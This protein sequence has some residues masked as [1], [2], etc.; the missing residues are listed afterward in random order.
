MQLK[1][2]ALHR[3]RLR[4]V[5]ALLLFVNSALPAGG[6][7]EENTGTVELTYTL[8]DR[9]SGDPIACEDAAVATIELLLYTTVGQDPQILS[10]PCNATA[11]APGKA[12]FTV[13]KGTY[14][15]M[16]IKMLRSDGGPSCRANRTQA[17]WTF[18]K[19]E[20]G[21]RV[22]AGGVAVLQEITAEFDPA[23]LPQCGNGQREACEECDDG[24]TESGDGCSAACLVES[25]GECGNGE[26]EPGE[27]CDDGNTESGDGCTA[28]CRLEQADLTVTWRPWDGSAEITCAD[29]PAETITVSVIPTGEATPVASQSDLTCTDLS[30]VFEDLAFGVYDIEILGRD[31][32]NTLSAFGETLQHTHTALEGSTATVDITPYAAP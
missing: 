28:D 26:V 20:A 32:E 12:A 21:A 13:R 5:T 31:A 17:K 15:E 2:K 9:S 23:N 8:L 16:Q 29:L 19:G 6:C 10:L 30:A 14:L 24:N 18:S 4:F 11:E 22:P 25:A 1:W 3:P 27:E 7:D